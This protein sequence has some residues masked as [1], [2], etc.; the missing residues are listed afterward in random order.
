MKKFNQRI[1]L[2]TTVFAL[3]LVTQVNGS[4]IYNESINGDAGVDPSSAALG[5]LVAGSSQ[6][7]GGNLNFDTDDYQ[8]TIG[9]GYQIDAIVVDSY[10]AIG[11][12]AMQSPF[13]GASGLSSSSVG[14]NFF[15]LAGTAQPVTAGNYLF[16]TTTGTGGPTT[17]QFSLQ[18]SAVPA[19]ATIRYDE[20]T[21]GDA[22]AGATFVDLGSLTDP[23][24]RIMGGNPDFD[25]DDYQFTIPSGYQLD[26]ILIET[27]SGGGAAAMQDPFLGLSTLDSSSVGMDF[28]DL[29]SV[30]QPVGAG[31]YLFRTTTGTAGPATYRY[32]L[33]IS[34]IP[35]P[36]SLGLLGAISAIAL[37]RKSR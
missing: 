36:A 13:L 4:T 17:Y 21:S 24:N 27:Y 31:T 35:E 9:A 10:T 3:G 19:P 28:L 5:T 15:T 18:V 37:R 8:F 34:A 32:D 20:A 7:I 29:A 1:V 25:S 16:R 12:A 14:Q 2:T 26:S 6:I 22:P 11:S 30:S 23:H 33:Q